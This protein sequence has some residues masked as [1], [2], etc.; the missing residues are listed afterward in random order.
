MKEGGIISITDGAVICVPPPGQHYLRKK[1]KLHNPGACSFIDRSGCGLL[2][3]APDRPKA[4]QNV[5]EKLQ[6]L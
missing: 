5:E 3:D 4:P 6:T 2:N 1:N